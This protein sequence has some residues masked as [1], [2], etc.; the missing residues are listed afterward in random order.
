MPGST[1]GRDK[2][3]PRVPFPALAALLLAVAIAVVAFRGGLSSPP[4]NPGTSSR[5]A[6]PG[7][8]LELQP[9]PACRYGSKP[10][11]RVGYRAWR[12]TLVDTTFRLP[13]TYTPPGLV[14]TVAA[15]F[16]AGFPIR[17]IVIKDLAALRQAAEAAGNPIEVVAG[18][19]SYQQQEHLF[20][21]RR[22]QLGHDRAVVKTA[23]PGHSEHQLGT[24]LDFKTKGA[25]D[26]NIRWERT[27]AG[28]WVVE[29]AWRFGF[30]QSYPRA[31][32]DVT[33]YADEPW[34]YRYIGRALAA[35]IHGSG[36]TTREFLWKWDQ[37][38]PS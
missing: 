29:N 8:S 4:S 16:E 24:T 22:A 9:L 21:E 14:S 35:Q 23:R 13:Q 30:V 17:K 31:K 18:Y 6:S 7:P 20:D 3:R 32:E 11:E 12:V 33:C 5:G 37:E 10:A 27:P 28:R 1:R 36:L 19:R 38:H 34:H 2:A 26:V 25:Q 15:G